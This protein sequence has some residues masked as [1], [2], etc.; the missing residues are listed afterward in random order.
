MILHM[1]LYYKIFGLISYLVSCQLRIVML[2]LS[3]KCWKVLSISSLVVGYMRRLLYQ[4][5]TMQFLL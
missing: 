5:H 2:L 4:V 3:T 1:P